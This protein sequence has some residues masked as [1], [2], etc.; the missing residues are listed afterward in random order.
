VGVVLL[1]VI[2]GL[3]GG[4]GCVR[5]ELER[6][7]DGFEFELECRFCVDDLWLYA[8]GD[9]ECDREGNGESCITDS[10]LCCGGGGGGGGIA[11]D[12]EEK[13]VDDDGN[14]ME[15]EEG[16]GGGEEEEAEGEKDKDKDDVP[17]ACGDS[18]ALSLIFADRRLSAQESVDV[19]VVLD[20]LLA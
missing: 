5:D 15:E 19:D 6:E 7:R 20:A 8:N 18:M 17:D 10:L 2:L 3:V 16:G 14:R 9:G 11:T 1:V 13:E 12:I 4:F